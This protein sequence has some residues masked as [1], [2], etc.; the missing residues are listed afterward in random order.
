MMTV[1]LFQFA[2][3]P[4]IPSPAQ[5]SSAGFNSLILNS[6]FTDTSAID[7]SSTKNPGYQW[8]M[9][10]SWPSELNAGVSSPARDNWNTVTTQS[11]S[12]LSIQTAGSDTFLRCTDC[13]NSYAQTISTARY[14]TSAPGYV[15][16][17]F[18]PGGYFECR[19][20]FFETSDYGS[21]AFWMN[22]IE[23]LTG[24][25][26]FFVEADTMESAGSLLTHSGILNW[27]FNVS[28]AQQITGTVLTDNS[29]T[30]DQLFHKWGVLWLTKAQNG[31]TGVLKFYQDDVLQ[32]TVAAPDVMDTHHYALFLG[33]GA[34][35]TS[36]V[37]WVR[38]WG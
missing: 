8:Y 5:A 33:N 24:N 25:A 38:V 14:I 36:D 16:T 18:G 30:N 6:N 31:G 10:S 9:C 17:V 34:G 35:H 29:G 7:L 11:S 32:S 26:S 28:P 4:L 19:M 20:R 13:S 12:F 27:N 22:P 21:F 3:K 15:G 2:S 1:G 23:N 37:D